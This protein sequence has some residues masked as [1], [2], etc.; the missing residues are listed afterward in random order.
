MHFDVRY[1][2]VAVEGVN[3]NHCSECG[4]YFKRPKRVVGTSQYCAACYKRLFE[5]RKCLHC[6]K[7]FR[8]LPHSNQKYCRTCRPIYVPCI[9]CDRTNYKIGM[10]SE[11]GPVCNRCVKYFVPWKTCAECNQQKPN[12]CKSPTFG[13]THLICSTCKEKYFD[14]CDGC[15]RKRHPLYPKNALKLCKACLTEGERQCLDCK[16]RMPAGQGTRC[17]DCGAINLIKRKVA[18]EVHLFNHEST[19]DSYRKFSLW[20]ANQMQPVVA[21]SKVVNY[22]PF[23]LM[24][25]SNPTGWWTDCD[26]LATLEKGELRHDSLPRKFFR[27]IGIEISRSSIANAAMKRCINNAV[28]TLSE[29]N[30]NYYEAFIGYAEHYDNKYRAEG[31]TL[32]TLKQ[33]LSSAASFKSYLTN[34]NMPLTQRALDSF[35][36]GKPG[37]RAAISSLVSY[38]NDYYPGVEL[39]VP[40]LRSRNP[41]HVVRNFLE[42]HRHKRPPNLLEIKAMLE[43][44]HNVPR[45]LSKTIT[46]NEVTFLS[47]DSFLVDT[48]RYQYIVSY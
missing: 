29:L 35:L 31:I 44:L 12:V 34:A 11:S 22:V 15:G 8:E 38:L 7:G 33:A 21:S 25:D 48:P 45:Q 40:A 23:F 42:H 1:V 43:Y 13:I 30:G 28:D 27:T 26:A 18:F 6:S 36:K 37:H 14:A 10:H 39:S 19:R 4:S 16:T 17:R 46:I 24:V 20:L 2:P 47:K 9:R 3:K 32:R 5:K 41:K